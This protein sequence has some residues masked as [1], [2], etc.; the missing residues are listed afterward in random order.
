MKRVNQI[1]WQPGVT[2]EEIEKQVILA[3]L[4]Y[5]NGHRG[6]TALALGVTDRTIRNKLEKYRLEWQAEIDKKAE[7]ERLRKEA[8]LIMQ[9]VGDGQW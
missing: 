4:K 2:L 6:A 5:F 9:G 8:R 7:S 1:L 3:C